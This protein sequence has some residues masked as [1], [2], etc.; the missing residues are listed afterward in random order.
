MDGIIA[1]IIHAIIDSFMEFLAVLP[2]VAIF[3]VLFKLGELWDWLFAARNT[4]SYEPSILQD[5]DIEPRAELAELQEW[6]ARQIALGMESQGELYDESGARERY[7]EEVFR[8][9]LEIADENYQRELEAG[10]DDD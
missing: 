2:C 1:A 4:K 6:Q 3:A 9:A 10:E 8:R 5:V 7:G